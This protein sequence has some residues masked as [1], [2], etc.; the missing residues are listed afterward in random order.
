[1]SLI[2]GL[3]LGPRPAATAAAIFAGS[4]DPSSGD[5]LAAAQPAMYVQTTGG[6][7]T[8]WLKTGAADTAWTKMVSQT[9]AGTVTATAFR[10]D[11]GSNTEPTFGI[12]G[13]QTGWYSES[14]NILSGV[15]G[16]TRYFRV[17]A[18]QVEALNAS[19]N[20]MSQVQWSGAV[21]PV[22]L[23]AQ[24]D[25][26]NPASFSGASALLLDATGDVTITGLIAG[27]NGRVLPVINVSSNT[28]TLA[29]ASGSSTAANQFL[30]P[31][32][33]D[34]DLQPGQGVLL[35]YDNT[36]ARWRIVA[37][38]EPNIV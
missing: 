37:W 20:A 2:H 27:S 17:R 22:A 36:A 38:G 4:D 25:D 35:F 30:A 18:G 8:M 9:F 34:F 19:L 15:A 14:A 13:Q 28:I 1:M 11:A 10:G 24:A 3:G 6:V 5:G 31:L 16:G 12:T 21:S 7:S 26:Y 23:T 32:G 29:H 33:E